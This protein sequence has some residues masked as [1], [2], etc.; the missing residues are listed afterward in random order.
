MTVDAGGA[1]RRYQVP[2]AARSSVPAGVPESAVISGAAAGTPLAVYDAVHDEDFRT[3]LAKALDAGVSVAG[4]SVNDV[5]HLIAELVE[6][7][8]SF[9]P[10]ETKVIVSSNR[11]DYTLVNTSKPLDHALFSYLTMRERL[12]RVR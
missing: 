7:A 4:T 11:I 5:V 12:T 10:R 6:N 8:I 2:L 3:G 9:S 1:T